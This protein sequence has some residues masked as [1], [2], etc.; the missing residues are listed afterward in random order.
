[1][2]PCERFHLVSLQR[3]EVVQLL[4]RKLGARGFGSLVRE[5]MHDLTMAQRHEIIDNIL[6]QSLP[7]PQELAVQVMA[8]ATLE[9]R[10]T[11]VALMQSLTE[12]LT[13]C[14]RN[15]MI[16]EAITAA[17]GSIDEAESAL[18][19]VLQSAISRQG[20]MD[21]ADGARRAHRLMA[22][23][24]HAMTE[25][26][27]GAAVTGILS[28]IETDQNV[29]ALSDAFVTFQD[30]A[31]VMKE[32][33]E[34]LDSADLLKACTQLVH[35][36]SSSERVALIGNM[37]SELRA[38]ELAAALSQGCSNQEELL[39]AMPKETLG[40]MLAALPKVVDGARLAGILPPEALQM[41]G[42]KMIASSPLSACKNWLTQLL[43]QVK[44]ATADS[45]FAQLLVG[46]L[47]PEAFAYAYANLGMGE[48]LRM[49]RSVHELK[50][51]GAV[52]PSPWSKQEVDVLMELLSLRH[53]SESRSSSV[54][55]SPFNSPQQAARLDGRRRGSVVGA[56]PVMST[57]AKDRFQ[58]IPLDQTART[59][60]DLYQKKVKDDQTADSLSKPRSSMT[61]FLR[62]YLTR[63]YGMKVMAEKA[64]REL[65]ATIRA[66]SQSGDQSLVRMRMFGEL[67]GMIKSS[68]GVAVTAWHERKVDF[69]FFVLARLARCAKE[70]PAGLPHQPGEAVQ[71]MTL[72]DLRRASVSSR[73]PI[74]ELRRTSVS[75]RTSVEDLKRATIGQSRLRRQ[76][77]AP[78]GR[79]NSSTGSGPLVNGLRDL[80]C[81]EDVVISF[82]A[83]DSVVRVAVTDV[84]LCV[85]L[86][87]Q[88]KERSMATDSCERG[89]HID[90]ALE[91]IMAAWD[92]EEAR[93]LPRIE[94]WLGK[95]FEE[96]DK[97]AGGRMSFQAFERFCRSITHAQL[98]EECLL[99]IFDEAIS[100]TEKL[101]GEETDT[102]SA[103]GLAQVAR[104]HHLAPNDKF[105][106]MVDV[107]AVGRLEAAKRSRESDA[108]SSVVSVTPY[109]PQAAESAYGGRR[110]RFRRAV[111]KASTSK[112]ADQAS[113][114]KH[115]SF[116]SPMPESAHDMIH[117]AIQSHFLFRHLDAAMH[118]EVVQRMVA[119]PVQPGQDVI[120]Q[121]D[122]GDYFYVA[123]RGEFDVI[124]G[125][126]K[127]HTYVA[128]PKERKHPCFG[129]LALLYAKPRAA[130]IRASE[131]GLLWGLDRRGFR[132]VQMS[133][134]NVDLTK[135]LRRM[136]I[137]ASLPFNSLQTLM[138]HMQEHTFG[139]GEM[140][141]R[142]GA[143]PFA[144]RTSALA[145]M[146]HA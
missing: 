77:L 68:N 106:S 60:A 44:S 58:L 112:A 79:L 134:S 92:Q 104:K 70:E 24:T 110:D 144:Q 95:A 105:C 62:N 48:R 128:D 108:E 15:S 46:A 109:R 78:P 138:N 2:T 3:V 123:E 4:M 73:T 57:R 122:K 88:M 141:F 80:L 75:S 54:S 69:F 126:E 53:S 84:E 130:T 111:N 37:M 86:G 143:R 38:H 41:W 28:G 120:R 43:V 135:L 114:A 17:E 11:H 29:S 8:S 136:D 23:I 81:K 64:L 139:A 51:L 71:R 65:T 9:G 146:C 31:T 1:M 55:A 76:S 22:K 56:L 117:S 131:E 42:S 36:T 113:S 18:A 145:S 63:Q 99:D 61:A 72:E 96:A 140:V 66:Y 115:A 12:C 124:V 30:P 125:D 103:G 74:E 116:A 33:L 119:F 127:V 137:L 118:R 5:S 35:D 82:A 39:T 91:L 7:L 98:D 20:M 129:E 13:P 107:V 50:Q 34:R 16:V 21:G 90:D 59:I 121:G 94:A 85:Q 25:T 27:R 89:L 52:S 93:E 83:I 100:A 142:Q 49:L 40:E 10:D 67:T 32:L 47:T 132:S 14:E 133:G 97:E 102:V 45:T 101:G 26:T 19:D 87:N 6:R